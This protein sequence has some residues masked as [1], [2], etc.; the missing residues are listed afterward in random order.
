MK[1]DIFQTLSGLSDYRD[2]L[3]RIDL[4]K[5]R[6]L[7]HE[8][9]T[10]DAVWFVESGALRIAANDDGRDITLQF[11]FEGQMAA[12][13]ESFYLQQPSRLALETIE[14]CSLVRIRRD[15][16]L[17]WQQ[18]RPENQGFI[19]AW[20]CRRLISYTDLFLSRI[21]NSPE[22]SYRSLLA[23][24]PELLDRVPHHYIASYLG[25][26]PVSLSRIRSRLA[27]KSD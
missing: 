14:A 19:T 8:G 16:F 9:D 15:T 12:S 6:F 5:N 11:F 10:A 25:I 26:T 17:R 23:E 1:P 13:F 3:S 22:Q 20:L 27:G 7:L 21:K 24:Q 4:P 2:E 18:G